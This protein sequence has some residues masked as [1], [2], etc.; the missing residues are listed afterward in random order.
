[1]AATRKQKEALLV[2]SEDGDAMADRMLGDIAEEEGIP[3][4]WRP[5]P[6]SW[7]VIF[8]GAFFHCGQI[9]G[10]DH[11]YYS[12]APGSMQIFETGAFSKFFGEGIADYCEVIPTNCIVRKGPTTHVVEWPFKRVVQQVRRDT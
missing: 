2:A 6:G 11:E 1:M 9:L 8:T 10:E 7:V 4:V 5:Q 3:P 12:L